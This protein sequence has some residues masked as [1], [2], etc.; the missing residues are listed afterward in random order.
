MQPC[1]REMGAWERVGVHPEHRGPTSKKRGM[2]LALRDKGCESLTLVSLTGKAASDLSPERQAELWVASVPFRDRGSPKVVSMAN[3][4]PLKSDGV[5]IQI[6]DQDVH[7]ATHLS[8]NAHYPATAQVDRWLPRLSGGGA[9]AN[10][11]R[12]GF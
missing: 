2:N 5:E 1:P 9:S 6:S 4:A 12:A 10:V 8:A 7:Q 3:C 11:A